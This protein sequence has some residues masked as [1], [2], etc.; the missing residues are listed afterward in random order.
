[1]GEVVHLDDADDPRLVDYVRLADPEARRR[2]ERDELFIA[3][4]VT[5]IERLLTSGHRVRSVLLT[6]K[7][8]ARLAD[9]LTELDA[10][11]YVAPQEVLARTVG[12]DLHRGAVAAADRQPLSSVD[13][14][15]ELSR[16]LAVLEGLNDPENVG[17]IARSARALGIDGLVLDPTCID[18]YYRRTIRVSMGEVLHLR[19][20]RAASW[21]ADL[22]RLR[23]HGFE[24]WALTPDPS[25]DDLFANAVPDR[26]AVLLGAE[27]GGLSPGALDA[28]D[29]QVRIPMA[30]GADSLN[31]GHAAAI[32]FARLR[33]GE[34]R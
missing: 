19:V 6:P 33:S 28:A 17:A 2:Q 5:A 18:P 23:A 15:A 1:M 29:R 24:A 7:A 32:A 3:E 9:R 20:A 16:R 31:V 13:E 25:A 12:F 8:H 22:D 21:P 14:V 26:V 10:P 11:V 4:G 34:V 30:P 27:G